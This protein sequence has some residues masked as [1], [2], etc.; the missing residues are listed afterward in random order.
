MQNSQARHK[1]AQT[2]EKLNQF[3]DTLFF[4]QLC[5]EKISDMAAGSAVKKKAIY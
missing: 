5:K 4:V 2:K 3:Q 1:E